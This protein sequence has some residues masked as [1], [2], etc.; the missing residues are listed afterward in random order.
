MLPEIIAVIKADPGVSALLPVEPITGE[1]AVFS[2]WSPTDRQPYI[3]V[4]H[5]EGVVANMDGT[6]SNGQLEINIWDDGTSLARLRAI[7]FRIIDLLDYTDVETERGSSRI[8]LRNSGALQ[9][10]TPG[11]SRWRLTFGTRTLRGAA[12]A[13]RAGRETYAFSLLNINDASVEELQN[14]P[15][16]SFQ[17]ASAIEQHRLDTGAFAASEELLQVNGV[18]V[19]TFDAIQGLITV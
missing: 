17:V 7:S 1:P 16:V 11:V 18:G 3:V 15:L 10:P 13:A 5:D 8:K 4:A 6:V 12:T 9:E 2:H 14:L 19:K